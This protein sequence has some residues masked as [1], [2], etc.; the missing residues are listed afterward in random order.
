M[1]GFAIV[2][3][4]IIG[5]LVARELAARLPGVPV[6][7]LDRDAV[8][9]GASR[10]SAGLHLP[11]GGSDRTRRM[12]AYSHDYYA[13]LA[14]GHPELPIYPL[15]ATVVTGPEDGLIERYLPQAN[16]VPVPVPLGPPGPLAPPAREQPDGRRAWRITGSHYCDVYRL[17]QA[18]ALRLRPAVEFAEGVAVTGL[19]PGDHGVTLHCGT[20]ARLEADGVILAP[21]PWLA[22]PAWRELISPLRLRVKR[23]VAL[24]IAR[25]PDPADEAILFDADD[26]FLLPLAHRGH[27]LF[28]YSCREWD[29]DPDKPATGLTSADMTAAHDCLRRYAPALAGACRGGQV[30]CDAYSPARE[31]V[32]RPLDP[33]GR[34]VFA[35]AAN[36]S[37]YR[38]AP[39]IAAEAVTIAA[40]AV[41]QL[42]TTP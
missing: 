39:A 36:G 12:S 23:V 9:S 18:L 29:V 8:G 25:R 17:T 27:W 32:I 22:A 15:G 16:P 7:V 42:V 14:R 33:A 35:G 38:L 37:G 10:R 13:S 6:T 3:A 4:G 26:C 20:G 40:E 30:F 28:S 5:C 41:T 24:H 1:A 19:I 21:G 11:R 2:G 34:I 31:P